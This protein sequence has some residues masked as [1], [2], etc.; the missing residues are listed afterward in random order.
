MTTDLQSGIDE[1]FNGLLTG[2]TMN[3]RQTPEE[4]EL[5]AKQAEFAKLQQELAQREL[6]LTTQE[7][8]LRAFESHYLRM[9]GSR[10]AALDEIEAKIAEFKASRTPENAAAR[11]KAKATRKQ[12]DESVQRSQAAD[13]S[14]AKAEFKPSEDLKKLYREV[15]KQIHPDLSEDEQERL[16]RERLMIEANL[17]F[18]NGDAERLRQILNEW[19]SSPESVKGDGTAA[20]LVRIIRK[21]ALVQERLHTIDAKIA[22]VKE[23]DLFQLKKRVEQ[24]EMGGIDLLERMAEDIDKR[25][26]AAQIKLDA[27]ITM[28]RR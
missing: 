16:R 22:A 2:S 5:S 13:T 12:A 24:S 1:A 8:D 4:R 19:E 7:I 17:A 6:D 25:I 23:S 28:H 27:V 14:S 26:A 18:E 9:G 15:A 10:Y 11:E 3:R 20:E 21:I